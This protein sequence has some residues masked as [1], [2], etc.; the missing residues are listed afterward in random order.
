[1]NPYEAD[2]AKIPETDRFADV[3]LYGRYYPRPDDFKP[4]KRHCNSTTPESL[5][6]WEEV[7][8]LCDTTVR[9]YENTDGGRDVFALETELKG[10]R[11]CR[12]YSLAD[13]NEVKA[14]A[15][16]KGI[17]K[18]I[19]IP[20]IYFAGK[21]NG[22]AVLVQSRIPGVGLNIAWQYIGADKK[23]SF[24]QQARDFL[25][26]LN[27]QKSPFPGPSYVVPDSKPTAHRGIQDKEAEI[28]FQNADVS[29][30][31]LMH[32]DLTHSN[33]IV[34]NDK[35]VGVV[36]W[37][38]AGY[39]GWER[40]ANV[41]LSIRSLTRECFAHLDLDEEFLLDIIYWNDLYDTDH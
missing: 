27:A 23:A 16:V 10:R 13:A 4:D 40:A 41:H 31:G 1:M 12:D 38:M 11:A 37:E 30:C 24:K 5:A 8:K 35:I 17:V 18:D 22:Q 36:D 20:E 9:I 28:L 6:Y 7:L 14:T 25:R 33:I 2:P 26:L 19:A 3:P 39:F 29:D 32:N 34:D 21:I 15:L